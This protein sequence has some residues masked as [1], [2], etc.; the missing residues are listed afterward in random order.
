MT[1]YIPEAS[2]FRN[3]ASVTKNHILTEKGLRRANRIANMI[4]TIAIIVFG[5]KSLIYC[6]GVIGVAAP[7][8]TSALATLGLGGGMVIGI[9]V[10]VGLLLVPITIAHHCINKFFNKRIALLQ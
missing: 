5:V 3:I 9:M 1:L 2:D 4:A 6:L 10:L 8:I 7:G